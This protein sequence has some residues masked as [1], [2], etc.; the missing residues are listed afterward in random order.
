MPDEVVTTTATNVSTGKPKIGGAV[1]R[2]PKGTTL[3]T[4]ATAALNAAFVGLGY[5]SEDG[6]T[7]KNSPSMNMTKAWGGD[8]VMQSQEEKNDNFGLT[9][10]ESLNIDVLKTVYGS[11]NVTGSA[12]AS[13]IAIKA[14]RKEPEEG[15]WVVDMIMRG[16][17]LK[18]VVIPDAIITDIGEITYN[19]TDP[20]GYALT[21][22]SFPDSTG[23]THYEYIQ[24]K[25]NGATGAS[26]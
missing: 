11:D 14:N 21:L 23:N 4:N 7:N 2:A 15:V 17:V 16:D 25:V 18:R 19:D 24:S 10:I 3:P 9:L 6:L 22:S 1:F 13:G 12:L 8:V 5:C 26:S 20:V